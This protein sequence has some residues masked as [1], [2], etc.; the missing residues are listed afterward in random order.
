MALIKRLSSLCLARTGLI[1]SQVW[2]ICICPGSTR[3]QPLV[4]CERITCCWATGVKVPKGSTE[5]SLLYQP[6]DQITA[7]PPQLYLSLF[8]SNTCS[9][10]ISSTNLTQLFCAAIHRAFFC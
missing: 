4:P 1:V 10:C 8:L 5:L 9:A 3:P 6:W 7:H 2:F